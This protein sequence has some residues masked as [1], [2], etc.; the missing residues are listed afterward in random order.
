M[1]HFKTLKKYVGDFYSVNKSGITLA[2]TKKRNFKTKAHPMIKSLFH[3]FLYFWCKNT[4]NNH[5]VACADLSIL[6]PPLRTKGKEV[7]LTHLKEERN[8]PKINML[9]V[10]I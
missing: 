9:F 1:R 5:G 7:A 10:N 6:T 3:L 8:L 4:Q 2:I